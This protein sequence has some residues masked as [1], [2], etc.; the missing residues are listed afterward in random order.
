[1]EKKTHGFYNWIYR[2][3]VIVILV[4]LFVV[5]AISSVV[6]VVAE[7]KTKQI[8][9]DKSELEISYFI[10]NLDRHFKEAEDI[11]NQVTNN[12][13]LKGL[14]SQE[15]NI[16]NYSHI[17]SVRA[18]QQ[19]QQTI[20]NGLPYIED[21]RTYELSNGICISTKAIKLFDAAQLK[22]LQNI[23]QYIS[24]QWLDPG[25]SCV[26]EPDSENSR[27]MIPIYGY[28][29]GFYC[30][31]IVEMNNEWIYE[32]V[33][34][35]DPDRKNNIG[36]FSA[37]GLPIYNEAF[38]DEAGIHI[39]AD[40]DT[41]DKRRIE[42]VGSERYLVT[43]EKSEINRWTYIAAVPESSIMLEIL[44]IRKLIIGIIAVFSFILIL[45]ML[46]MAQKLI[47]QL[48]GFKNLM[49]HLDIT[50]RHA[51]VRNKLK[52]LDYQ[53]GLVV[54]E[55]EN[56]KK[57]NLEIQNDL[58]KNRR[59]LSQSYLYRLMQ[60]DYSEAEWTLAAQKLNFDY[61]RYLCIIIDLK[62]G[63]KKYT[64]SLGY[65]EN[66]R[67]KVF[68]GV[69]HVLSLLLEE[70]RD[71]YESYIV[72][73]INRSRIYVLLGFK[74][75]AVNH[76]QI[77]TDMYFYQNILIQSMHCGSLIAIG[78]TVDSPAE[79]SLSRQA[80]ETLL[81]P[82]FM[83][84]GNQLL[85][86][87][88]RE[89]EEFQYSKYDMARQQLKAGLLNCSNDDVKKVL[90]EHKEK[91]KKC[92]QD[93]GYLYCCKDIINTVYEVSLERGI[94]DDVYYRRLTKYFPDI[95]EYFLDFD[96]FIDRIADEMS[97]AAEIVKAVCYS[98]AIQRALDIIREEYQSNLSL[99]EV[100][101][102]LKIS[103]PYLSK[104]FKQEV[105]VSFKEYLTDMKMKKAKELMD[106]SGMTLKEI[107]ICVGY[108]DYK[109]FNVIFKKQFGMTAGEYRKAFS[110][111]KEEQT[112][113]EE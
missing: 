12:L 110:K 86:C 59:E 104:T 17:E 94:T 34:S 28:D 84:S 42:T 62:L 101:D 66:V 40:S 23:S 89:N 11:G 60:G 63:N 52:M 41:T 50:D 72:H 25:E 21:V 99:Q 13:I 6:Y 93:V 29:Q 90:Q 112:K 108:N 95:E 76:Y 54:R 49:M 36:I 45:V 71:E 16:A 47:V 77:K 9:F 22:K 109:Q 8:T 78:E 98:A 30:V 75:R 92:Y 69:S 56:E 81:E 96:E 105:G 80:A 64:D 15:F 7:D 100:A 43:E 35:N 20:L 65:R 24:R 58:E 32:Q 57:Q 82:K 33:K 97:E 44:Q 1:M 55:L 14:I 73:S 70:H 113:G 83:L 27:L 103:E 38:M 87:E 48:T 61:E 2:E 91:I 46:Y 68:Y 37:H 111:M 79:I 107:A 18:I 26:I 67:E 4:S 39:E 51:G 88:K 85:Y 74:E 3:L 53:I 106:L 102:E 31:V 10:N 5:I 19:F